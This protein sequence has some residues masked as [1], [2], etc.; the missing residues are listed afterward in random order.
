MGDRMKTPARVPLSDFV[1]FV[2]RVGTSNVSK[3]R[4][5]RKR[6]RYRPGS[7]VSKPVRHAIEDHHRQSNE[8]VRQAGSRCDWLGDR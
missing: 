1:E 5:L 7:D 3:V 2:M 6:D 8:V 4:E